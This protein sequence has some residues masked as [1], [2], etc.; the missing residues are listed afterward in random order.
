M[1]NKKTHSTKLYTWPNLIWQSLLAVVFMCLVLFSLNEVA[2]SN[3]LWAVGAGALAS[4]SY[5]VFGKP[6]APSA[7]P[8]KI[9]GGYLV[10]ILVGG[11]IRFFYNQF[12]FFQANLMGLSHFHVIGMLAAIAVGLTLVFMV[13]LKIEHPP[14]A[15]MA[16]ALVLDVHEFDV[17]FVVFFAMLLLASLRQILKK[18][19]R[20][21]V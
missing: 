6:H 21:L 14:A 13:L 12:P 11:I 15:G 3:I 7:E 1:Q 19:M 10:A 4:S 9:I 16:L 18:Y 5:L 2:N 17:V 20:N 8:V